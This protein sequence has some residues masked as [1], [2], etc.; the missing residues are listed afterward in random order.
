MAAGSSQQ[1]GEMILQAILCV[2]PDK[3]QTGEILNG[4]HAEQ[5]T[6]TQ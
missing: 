4:A 3:F 6:D 5:S 2:L 1:E